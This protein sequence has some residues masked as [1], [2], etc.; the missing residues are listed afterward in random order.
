MRCWPT[1][2]V[3]SA[4]EHLRRIHADEIQHLEFHAATLPE[5]LDGW[6]TSIWHIAR[7]GWLSIVTASAAVVAVDHRRALRAAVRRR[8]ASSATLF[9]P[10]DP[11]KQV[12]PRLRGLTPNRPKG[13]RPLCACRSTT[14]GDIGDELQEQ[15]PP[16]VGLFGEAVVVSR[17]EGSATRCL[18]FGGKFATLRHE[19]GNRKLVAPDRYTPDL[20]IARLFVLRDVDDRLG[21]PVLVNGTS[22]LGP[23]SAA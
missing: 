19:A 12:L 5:H 22:V 10:C 17:E 21:R 11:S 16:V 1:V 2:S 14:L 8:S 23:P 18:F 6:P 15:V 7:I 4:R 3:I 9:P 20:E 13:V